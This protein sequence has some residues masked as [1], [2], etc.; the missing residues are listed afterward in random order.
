MLP[1]VV[2]DDERFAEIVDRAKGRISQIMPEWTDHNAHD[3]GITILELFAWMK[4]MQQFHMDR[5]T[6]AH[7]LSFLRLMGIVP[8]TIRAAEA[9]V[10]VG[11]AAHP[12]FFPRGSR[13]YAGEVCFEAVREIRVDTAEIT[14]LSVRAGLGGEQDGKA[15]G[16]T[17][18]AFGERAGKYFG[19]WQYK[20]QHNEAVRGGSLL[21][22]PAF[23]ERPEKESLLRME[24]SGALAPHVT[25]SIHIRLAKREGFQ[26]NPIKDDGTFYPLAELSL[27]YRGV[28]GIARA[29]I[30]KDTT[31]G[32]LEDG[33]LRF[34]INGEMQKEDGACYLYLTPERCEYEVPPLIAGISLHEQPAVQQRTIAEYHDGTVC[35]G[36]PIRIP[37]YLAMTGAFLLFGREERFFVPYDGNVEKRISDEAAFFFLPKLPKG[38]QFSYRIVFCE[39]GAEETLRIGEGRGLPNQE[40]VPGIS[41]LCADGMCLMMELEKGSGR[42]VSARRCEDFMQAGAYDAVFQYEEESGTIRFGDCDH[43]MPPEGTILFAA[44]HS[45]LGAGGNVKAQS[46]RRLEDGERLL[47]VTNEHEAAGGKNTETLS[48]C[49]ERLKRIREQTIRAVTDADFERLVMQTQGLMVE[50][51]KVIKAAQKKRRQGGAKDP[52]EQENCV[53]V[54]VKPCSVYPEAHLSEAYRKNILRA[55]ERARPIGTRVLVL[56]PEYIGI[57]LF[58]EIVVNGQEDAARACIEEA[59][60]AFFAKIGTEFG[61]PVRMSALYGTLDVLSVTARIVSLSFNARGNGIRRSRGGDLILPENGLAYLQECELNVTPDR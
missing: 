41:G 45:S 17:G 34:R 53:T 12:V 42:Y 2:L 7:R 5:I 4:E 18:S 15:D 55:L 61:A 23:G 48:E 6:K 60:K 35:G 31:Y 47:F 40:Y 20:W 39:A 27:W 28:H 16:M 10:A 9:V 3:P 24:L 51:V 26:R 37:T 43:G 52:E 8:E 54:V 32:L 38:A 14:G 30:M 11:G 22:L 19:A 44:A 59:L 49:N 56:S 1:Q 25:H 29:E 58:G 33:W 57:S 13:F 46:I 50:S 36:E 21:R